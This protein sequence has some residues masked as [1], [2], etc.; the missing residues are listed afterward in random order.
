MPIARHPNHAAKLGRSSWVGIVLALFLVA[1]QALA[2]VHGLEHPVTGTDHEC[3]LCIGGHG[4]DQLA[5]PQAA[6]TAPA[7][8]AG[9]SSDPGAL[10]ERT[11]RVR[12]AYARGPPAVLAP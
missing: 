9:V 2:L 6:V 12:S 5:V 3:P 10:A 8:T 11:V 4:L 1:T 7:G